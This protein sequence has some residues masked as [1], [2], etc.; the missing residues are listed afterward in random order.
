MLDKYL[1]FAGEL[2]EL[3]GDNCASHCQGTVNN[4]QKSSKNAGRTG[5]LMK[6][7]D[8]QDNK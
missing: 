2:R 8:H 1:D 6:N 5:N 4:L 3:E 7:E